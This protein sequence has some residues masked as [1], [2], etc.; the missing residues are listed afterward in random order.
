[1][2]SRYVSIASFVSF[3][4]ILLSIK[5]FNI[6]KKIIYIISLLFVIIIF[7]TILDMCKL[8]I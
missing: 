4:T 2:K 7:L 3:I 8:T 6:K 1:M 5:N